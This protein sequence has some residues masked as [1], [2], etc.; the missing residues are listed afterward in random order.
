MA[1]GPL[2][3][4]IKVNQ[5]AGEAVSELPIL[6]ALVFETLDGGITTVREI[7]V[8]KLQFVGLANGDVE[9]SELSWCQLY[10]VFPHDPLLILHAPSSVT[11]PP[12][13]GAGM[14]IL[15]ILDFGLEGD[16][17]RVQLARAVAAHAYLDEALG[18]PTAPVDAGVVTTLQDRMVEIAWEGP[19]EVTLRFIDRAGQPRLEETYSAIG[20]RGV[21]LRARRPIALDT[22]E[23]H[24]DVAPVVV[25]RSASVHSLTIDAQPWEAYVRRRCEAIGCSTAVGE[26]AYRGICRS[27]PH[28]VALP[29]VEALRR[30]GILPTESAR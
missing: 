6:D 2:M 24:V 11:S 15:Q 8:Q 5:T 3:M 30:R 13:S 29:S 17:D 18:S 9:L 10:L 14:A 7:A 20:S 21:H 26:E 4:Q 1:K 27:L 22:R 25:S 19:G 23:G 12:I 28:P 16:P